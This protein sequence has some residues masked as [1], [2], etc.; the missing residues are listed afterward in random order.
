MLGPSGLPESESEME[1]HEQEEEEDDEVDAE[2]ILTDLSSSLNVSGLERVKKQILSQIADLSQVEEEDD[3][4]DENDSV[5]DKEDV[6]EKDEGADGNSNDDESD[7]DNEE[8]K[9]EEDEDND[10]A[11]SDKDSDSDKTE[12]E[13]ELTREQQCQKI[14]DTIRREEFGVGVQLDETGQKLLQVN[15]FQLNF[16]NSFVVYHSDYQYTA[17]INVYNEPRLP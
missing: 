17:L 12:E 5:E 1:E 13:V 3:D 15:L 10:S 16:K 9:E 14:V 11:A 4:V 2:D 8:E 6:A 7:D